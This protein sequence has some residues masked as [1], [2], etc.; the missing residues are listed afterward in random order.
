MASAITHAALPVI[1]LAAV[2]LPEGTRRRVTIAAALC[3]MLPDL[4]VV[5]AM[6]EIRTWEPMGHRGVSHSLLIAALVALFVT[7]FWFH[8]LAT[9]KREWRRVAL[10]LFGATASH[11]LLDALTTGEVGVAL[12]APL[13]DAR[14][15]SPWKLLPSCPVGMSEY[16]GPWGLFTLAN[17]LFYVL[18]PVGLV[19]ALV[20]AEPGERRRLYRAG[21]IWAL[22][23]VVLRSMFPDYFA[24]T[25]PRF[26]RGIAKNE[27]DPEEIPH[28]D[29]P[30]GKLVKRWSEL[31]ARNLFGRVLRPVTPTWSSSFFPSWFGGE[32]GRWTEGRPR[33]VWRTLFGFPAPTEAEARGWISAAN[34]GD[35]AARARLYSLAPTEKVDLVLGRLDFPATVQALALSHNGHPRYWHGRCNGIAGAAMKHPEPFRVVEVIG[36]DG[37]HVPFHPNDVKS[38]LAI[39]YDGPEIEL[40][41]GEMCTEVTL[42]SGALCSMNPALF[43]LAIA[44]R[45]GIGR[46]SFLIDA[47]PT[48]AKQYYAVANARMDVVRAPYP[49]AGHESVIDPAVKGRV[50]SLVDVAMELTLSSTTVSYPEADRRDPRDP[51]GTTYRKVGLVPVVMRWTATVGLDA[52]G[53]LFAGRWTGDP[54]DGPDDV[55]I[56]GGN[57]RLV[58]DGMLKAADKIPWSLVQSLARAS[59]DEGPAA[60]VIDLRQ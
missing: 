7:T 31:E 1:V 44:N 30:D 27:R 23:A 49:V 51:V 18:I 3:A 53:E 9:G 12:F 40:I 14:V 55:V 19:V 21:V 5:T 50:T 25:V 58:G 43:V 2:D 17:E 54:A 33:L 60:P 56:V 46:D 26:V 47:L 32:G 4:D 8:D 13:T 39:A 16:L 22:L 20:R 57:P 35:A 36:V 37:T 28:A 34:A 45:I 11:G 42:D 29:L 10:V 41:V 24:P 52:N 6:F 48:I 59:V 15:W 38:L